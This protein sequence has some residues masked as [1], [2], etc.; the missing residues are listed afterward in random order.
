MKR[1]A[2]LG[3]GLL[4]L[5]V[6]QSAWAQDAGSR[7]TRE[8]VQAAGQSDAF[9]VAEAQIALTQSRDPGVR[10]FAQ[11][12]LA[13]HDRLIRSL[14]QAATAAGLAPPPDGPGADQA[15]L[16]AGLQGAAADQFDQTY[17]RH[18]ALAHRSALTVTQLYAKAADDRR[19]GEAA[20]AALPVIARHLAMAEQMAVTAE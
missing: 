4:A 8:Y 6:A 2:N 5:F 14:A 13:D 1:L 12:M 10:A 3:A 17:W 16:L 11:E 20:S 7:P 9:E 19:I 15:L 18:Q